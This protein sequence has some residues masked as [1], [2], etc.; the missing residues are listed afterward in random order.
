[1]TKDIKFLL[2]LFFLICIKNYSQ[3]IMDINIVTGINHNDLVGDSLKLETKTFFAFKKMEKA[4]KKDGIILKI[5]SAHRTFERQNLI[6]NKKYDKFTKEYLKNIFQNKQTNI[7]TGLLDQ[8]IIAGIG[9][10]YANEIL[11]KAKI[12]PDRIVNQLSLNDLNLIIIS[13][14]EILKNSIKKGGTTIKNHRQPNGKLGYFVQNLKVYGKKN[15]KCYICSNL[16]ELI[17]ISNRSTY[18]CKNCQT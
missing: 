17:L 10:I 15:E 4:A 16:I 12:R 13:T 2:P 5:V 18:F 9:N 3:K 7:K 11:F 1:M 6:W 14:K 8:K